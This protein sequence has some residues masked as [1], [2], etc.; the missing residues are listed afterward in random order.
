[1]LRPI[2]P[3][4][5]GKV[6]HQWLQ[7]R[8]DPVLCRTVRRIVVHREDTDRALAAVIQDLRL[9]RQ[10]A[11]T[12]DTGIASRWD[13]VGILEQAAGGVEDRFVVVCA[14][15]KTGLDEGRVHAAIVCERGDVGSVD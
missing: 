6:L 2:R 9:T 15:G 13:N 3:R 12:I 1:M 10:I 4:T 5:V 7:T 14:S 8:S 11:I